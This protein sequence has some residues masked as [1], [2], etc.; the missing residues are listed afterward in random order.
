[1]N[2]KHDLVVPA[3]GIPEAPREGGFVHLNAGI[4]WVRLPLDLALGHINVWLLDDGDGW[5]LIDTGIHH[6]RCRD[7]WEAI[8][9][10]LEAGRPLRQILITHHHPDHIGLAGWL[11]ER[12]GCAVRMTR[13]AFTLSGRARQPATAEER[14][15]AVE[16]ARRHG[17]AAAL[18]LMV[19][20]WCGDY[21]ARIVSEPEVDGWLEDGMELPI[22]ER[23][24]RVALLQGHA[25][26]HAVLRSTDG[27]W[28]IAGDQVLPNISPN[29]SVFPS[30][31]LTDPVG[32]FLVSLDRLEQFGEPLICPAHGM[33]FRGLAARCA[34]LR[35]HHAEVLRR[36]LALCREPVTVGDV[37]TGLYPRSVGTFNMALAFGEALAHL[38]CL[39]VRGEVVREESPGRCL[40]RATPEG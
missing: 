33:P 18:E 8:L 13:T 9:P 21:Y 30:D 15:E 36:T 20:F 31:P 39:E 17:V 16:F 27:G 2:S 29:V 11:R 7:A 6:P 26:D 32:D 4:V 23:T 19:G 12:T 24:W 38:R 34:A 37:I 28:L 3:P 14:A 22:G 40:F 25:R 1:M 35:A 5:T 10:E